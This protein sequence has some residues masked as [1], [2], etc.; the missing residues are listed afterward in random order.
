MKRV[1]IDF[2]RRTLAM[3]ALAATLVPARAHAPPVGRHGG[4]Q[5]NAGPFHVELVQSDDRCAVYL[6]DHA[7]RIPEG[8]DRHDVTL[9]LGDGRA[10]CTLTPVTGEPGAFQTTNIDHDL[11]HGDDVVVIISRHAAKVRARFTTRHH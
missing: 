5:V 4:R 11:A 7:F 2:T 1:R 3:G 9:Q 8:I 10:T 6:T